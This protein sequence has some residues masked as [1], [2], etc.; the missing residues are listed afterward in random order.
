MTYDEFFD[1]VI[2]AALRE[3]G[4]ASHAPYAY[5]RQLASDP[6]PD[7][8]DVPTGLGKTAAVTGAWLYRRL[9][10]DRATPRRLVWCLPMRVLVEQTH[11]AVESWLGHAAPLFEQKGLVAP[12][13]YVLMGGEDGGKWVE[14]PEDPA[15]LIGTQDMLLS[16]ALMRGFGASRYRWPVDFALLHSDA[17]WVFDEVQLMGAGLATS[18]QVEAFRR[19]ADTPPALPTRTL[20]ASATLRPDWLG[21]VD[22]RSHLSELSVLRLPEED[23]SD[24]RVLKRFAAA[25][26]IAEAGARLGGSRKSDLDD[27]LKTLAEEVVA[28]HEGDAPTLVI[29]NRVARAQ[30]LYARIRRRLREGGRPTELLL[31]HARFRAAERSALNA[32]LRRLSPQDDAIVVAT[33]AIEAGVDITS[34]HLFTELAPWPSLVQRFGRCNRGGEYEDAWVRWIDVDTSADAQLALP[35]ESEALTIARELLRGIDS[36]APAD[37]P[38]VEQPYTPTHV[39]RRKDFL[40]L[41]NTEPDLSG[42]DIDV[43]PYLR[44]PGGADVQLFWRD[45][46]DQPG[47]QP[48]PVRGE[49]CT[50]SIGAA[51]DHLKALKRRAY[52][53]DS[54]ASEWAD[55]DPGLLRPGL[56]LMLP[57][58]AGGYDVELG[59]VSKLRGRVEPVPPAVPERERPEAMEDDLSASGDYVELS[60]HLLEARRQAAALAAAVRM[61]GAEDAVVEA[62]LWHDVGKAHPAFQTAILEHVDERIDRGRL[63]AKSPDARKRLSYGVIVDGEKQP[64][65]YFRHEL[66]SMLAWLEAGAGRG[67]MGAGGKE[68]AVGNVSSTY[69]DLV[70]YLIAAHHGKVR[71]VLRALPKETRPEEDV[72]FARGVW[73][74]D[75]LPSFSVNGLRLPELRLRLDL[76]QLGEGE[77]GPSWSARTA[78]LLERWGPFR[79]AWLEAMVRVADWRASE[80]SA[81]VQDPRD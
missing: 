18:A 56:N 12:R 62:A 57:A 45:F 75:T 25:K 51:R 11:S 36:A 30:D 55:L 79:L 39:L 60:D 8:L 15:V 67:P 38:P 42:F 14:R 32:R 70:A 74:G 13:A 53:W 68:A 65:R 35:Y 27:F 46:Q 20:W 40:D 71:L 47:E 10:R 49:L 76:M 50:V 78:A 41:F 37:L 66:A 1:G 4:V 23:R 19:R 77:M 7:V 48:P 43:S 44:D 28:S 22:F 63:W 52:V 33:Q 59:F 31:V 24:P 29:V 26:R 34:R 72:L 73:S 17:L 9:Q 16:R 2:A 80:I 69:S 5:Q 81:G 3:A 54:L 64:R 58:D 6:W 21:T 61:A